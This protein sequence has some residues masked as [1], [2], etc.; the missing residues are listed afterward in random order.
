[1]KKFGIIILL[2]VI[3]MNGFCQQVSAEMQSIV[4]PDTTANQDENTKFMLEGSD[5]Y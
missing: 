2:A 5:K 3:I 4:K 1:M